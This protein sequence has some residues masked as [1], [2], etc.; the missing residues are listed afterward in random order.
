MHGKSS[1]FLAI[2]ENGTSKKEEKM[3]DDYDQMDFFEHYKLRKKTTTINQTTQCML[4]SRRCSSHKDVEFCDCVT[5]GHSIWINTI[6]WF[7][8]LR[9]H[10]SEIEFYAIL[11]CLEIVNLCAVAECYRC[12][13]FFSSLLSFVPPPLAKQTNGLNVKKKRNVVLAA[14]DVIHLKIE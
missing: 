2:M 6:W 8:L 7:S 11:C 3:G 12:L 9:P 10:R 4:D 13:L 5:V 14:Y 1:L